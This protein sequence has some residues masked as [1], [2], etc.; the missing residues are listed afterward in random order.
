MELDNNSNE[1]ESFYSEHQVDTTKYFIPQEEMS[2]CYQQTW[3]HRQ[4]LFYLTMILNS[5]MTIRE[6][7]FFTTKYC[8]QCSK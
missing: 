4:K 5:Y 3:N 1:A 8:T 6:E 2:S 7:N